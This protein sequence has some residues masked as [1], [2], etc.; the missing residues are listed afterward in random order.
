MLSYYLRFKNLW[1][2]D[3]EKY[4]EGC[5]FE[6]LESP[7]DFDDQ[8]RLKNHF[9]KFLLFNFVD[10]FVTLGYYLVQIIYFDKVHEE[11]SR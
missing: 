6:I 7:N 9:E 4:E 11:E 1:A 8:V 5:Y 2:E 10:Y 3:F